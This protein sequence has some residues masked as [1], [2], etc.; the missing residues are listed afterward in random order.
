MGLEVRQLGFQ[1]ART[2]GVALALFGSALWGISG[3]VAQSLFQRHGF[4]AEWLTVVRL[5]ASGIIIL[6]Y[7]FRREGK[8]V[9]SLW[10]DKS[11]RISI[12]VFGILG[13][14]GVQY[15]YFA[16]ID[17]GNAATATVLQY[18]S[19]VLITGLLCIR[20]KKLPS[21]M[22]GI[23]VALA[24]LGTFLLVTG[25]SF[26]Q[27]SISGWT[28]FWGIASAFAAAFYTLQPHK[29][30]MKWGSLIIVGWGM[31]I[32][33]V[34]FS[35]VHPVWVVSGDW[36]WMSGISV[37][38][39]ILFGT[40]IAFLCYLESTKYISGAEASIF[41]SVE[42]LS[43]ALLSVFWLHVSFGLF[44]WLGTLC[45]LVTVGLLSFIR[46]D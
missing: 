9:L 16:A 12:L 25:G 2:R 26:T 41:A 44:E 4:S 21:L 19:P 27:L 18:L 22:I 23:S 11:S 5:L 31:L 34:G 13:M 7:A 45:I 10:S 35:F 39:V 29:L 40:I 8:R 3:T 33:G 6:T 32:G 20:L 14:L 28:L 37:L 43:A 17:H 38:F 1:R 30:L 42:P 15:T 24:V 46:K 36:S